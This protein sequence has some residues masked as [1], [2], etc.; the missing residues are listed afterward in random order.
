MTPAVQPILSRRLPTQ[1]FNEQPII[2]QFT[3]PRVIPS[4]QQLLLE[5]QQLLQQKIQESKVLTEAGTIFFSFSF[6]YFITF[7]FDFV[8]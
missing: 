7:E 5:Q 8:F 3:A 6:D 1:S 2:P 4:P